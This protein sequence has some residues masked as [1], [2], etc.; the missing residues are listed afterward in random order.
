MS[1]DHEVIATGGG[2]RHS[3]AWLRIMC[4]ALGRPVRPSEVR[5]ASARGAALL[6][7]E[8]LGI[9]GVEDVPA[10]V[11]APLEPDPAAHAV[12]AEALERQKLLYDATVGRL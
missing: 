12:Y 7:L 8:R 11:G 5:G 3:P 6:A 1:G 9:V 10:P 4:D 2:M